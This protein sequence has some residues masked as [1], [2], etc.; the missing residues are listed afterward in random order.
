MKKFIFIFSLIS[1]SQFITNKQ[2]ESKNLSETIKQIEGHLL[3]YYINENKSKVK[4]M[5]EQLLS[6]DEN[7]Y[8]RDK[9][10]MEYWEYIDDYMILNDRIAPDGL[11][12]TPDHAFVVL[13]YVLNSDGSLKPEAKGRCDVAYESAMKY[14]NSLIF[15]TGGGTA[16]GN[17]TATEGGQMKEYLVNVKGLD[18]NRIITETRAMDTIQ[19]A[20][21]TIIELIEKN[22]KTITVITSD[23]HVRR[24]SILFKGEALLK[25]E[26][27]G[28]TPIKVLENAVY[29]TDKPTEG[30][31]Y[32]GYALASILDVKIS[33]DMIIKSIPS[34]IKEGLRYIWYYK[35]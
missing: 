15:V 34:L 14:P 24:G 4:E 29:K 30:K 13:G 10:I 26:S 27:M 9:E 21:Y 25:A 2:I 5:L 8:L 7:I 32:E 11:P 12:T 22:I 17:K 18:E 16:S 1:L 31:Y 20:E 6:L 35:E 19:N 23:Y 33:I 28:I 3:Y